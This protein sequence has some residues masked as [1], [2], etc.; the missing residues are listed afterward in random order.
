MSLGLAF[1]EEQVEKGK[2]DSVKAYLIT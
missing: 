2:I 1:D